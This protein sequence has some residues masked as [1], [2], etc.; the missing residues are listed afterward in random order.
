MQK[1]YD[2]S[3]EEMAAEFGEALPDSSLNTNGNTGI[4]GLGIQGNLDEDDEANSQALNDLLDMLNSRENSDLADEL[5]KEEAD[6]E[7]YQQAEEARIAEIER[8]YNEERYAKEQAAK[9]ERLAKQKEEEEKEEEEER[10]RKENS[11]FG[12]VSKLFQKK[13][14]AVEIEEIEEPDDIDEIS[15]QDEESEISPVA[16]AKAESSEDEDEE[17]TVSFEEAITLPTEEEEED[18]EDTSEEKVVAIKEKKQ[19]K[20][21]FFAKPKEKPVKEKPV[22][23]KIVKEKPVKE[24]KSK[25]MDEPDWKFI[26][27]HD[28]MT[29]LL[30]TRAYNER[31]KVLPLSCAVIFFDINN[32]KYVNDNFSHEDGNKLIKETS[33]LIIK[34][35]GKENAYRIG[36]D[37]F[38]VLLDTPPH[39]VHDKFAK[40][41]GEIHA[42]LAEI[43]KKDN[44]KIP[45]AVS[46]GYAIGDKKRPVSDVIKAADTAM[47]R[48]KKAYK[49]SH[50]NFNMR[51]TDAEKTEEKA[52]NVP[53]DYDML[54]SREQREL[55]DRIKRNHKVV[56]NMSTEQIVR[57]IQKHASEIK[58]I[59]IASANFDHLFIIKDVNDF[60]SVVLNK[61]NVID[62][63]YLYVVYEG[64]P[65][66]YGAQEYYTDVTHIFEA[67]TEGMMSG[68]FRTAKDIQ[69]IKGINI[70]KSIYI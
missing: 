7:A 65:C 48:N 30:N 37:E 47:Y 46:A 10:L 34:H 58:A 17:E 11:F 40:E 60:I 64:G 19:K 2:L 13:S 8:K 28:D 69:S 41:I 45:Y 59:F 25:A 52:E 16:I 39:N 6:R 44:N 36:G 70:F 20:P 57:E 66:Y 53:V 49:E 61:S 42:S 50:P 24:V 9:E 31:L 67:I 21:L 56:S 35:F 1:L 38:V 54:L 14:K 15:K 3:E 12:K 27:Q 29:G 63:S 55:K 43:S 51:P 5:A 22:K 68:K 33:A 62:Y 18:E 23:E 32:L 26:A 4:T